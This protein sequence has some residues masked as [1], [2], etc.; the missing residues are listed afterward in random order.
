MRRKLGHAGMHYYR[1]AGFTKSVLLHL[2]PEIYK[3]LV[4]LAK[5]EE[6][7]I[8]ITARRI[9]EGKLGNTIKTQE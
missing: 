3:Q 5:K 4:A 9:L 7:S 8:Q 2:S 6:R 1:K